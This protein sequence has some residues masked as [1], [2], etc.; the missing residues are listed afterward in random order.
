[1]TELGWDTLKLRRG[2]QKH[3]LFFKIVK[4]FSASYLAAHV[5]P[6]PPSTVGLRPTRRKKIR[7]MPIYAVV[8]SAINLLF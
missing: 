4:G 6:F 7:L 2:Y 1:M 3:V 8:Y 5:L